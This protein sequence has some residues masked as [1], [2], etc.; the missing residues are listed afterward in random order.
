MNLN[1]KYSSY[2][3][4]NKILSRVYHFMT[5][6]D[7]RITDMMTDLIPYPAINYFF[8]VLSPVVETYEEETKNLSI[9]VEDSF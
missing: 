6:S 9:N 2:Q 1:K 4:I 5:S 3:D 8:P 7:L